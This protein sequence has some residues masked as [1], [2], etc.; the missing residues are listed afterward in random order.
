MV[1]C[2]KIIISG[3]CFTLGSNN[4]NQTYVTVGDIWDPV[5]GAAALA[6]KPRPPSPWLHRSTGKSAAL[7]VGS[8]LFTMTDR[9]KARR[10]VEATPVCLINSCSVR[11]SLVTKTLRHLNS[12]FPAGNRGFR[13]RGADSH[14]PSS[15]PLLCLERLSI[16]LMNKISDKGQTWRGPTSTRSLTYYQKLLHLLFF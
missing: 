10:T 5:V 15:G 8:A 2:G 12:T 11:P 3:G 4:C 1:L 14:P 16:K 6:G 9:D 7:P 13:F